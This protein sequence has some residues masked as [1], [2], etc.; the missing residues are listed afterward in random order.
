MKKIL[1]IAFTLVL[2]PVASAEVT[3][4]FDV[5]YDNCLKA[6]GEINNGSVAECSEKTSTAAKTEINFLYRKIYEMLSSKSPNDAAKF[7]Q[8]QKAW[9]AYRNKHCEL[10]TDY[11]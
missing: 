6:A 10:A 1:L 9:L 3:N 7:E 2:S 11:V 5:I 4:K 8:S